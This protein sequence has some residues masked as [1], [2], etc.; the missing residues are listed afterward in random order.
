VDDTPE[1]GASVPECFLSAQWTRL[2]DGQTAGEFEQR[3]GAIVA[4][5]RDRQ[6]VAA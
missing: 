2:V 1:Y 4:Q 6:G 5:F 3:L